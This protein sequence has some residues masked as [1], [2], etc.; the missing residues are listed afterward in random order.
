[1]NLGQ[2]VV[3]KVVNSGDIELFSSLKA[4]DFQAEFEKPVYEFT[5]NYYIEYGKLPSY[6]MIANKFNLSPI[7][8]TPD[9][10]P[11]YWI[12]ELKK[13]NFLLTYDQGINKINPYLVS[14]NLDEAQQELI[15]L[16]MGLSKVGVSTP[17]PQQLSDL[18]KSTLD[19][20]SDRRSSGGMTGITCGF[21]SLS[22]M[23]RGFTG[24]NCYVLAGRKKLGKSM[25]LAIMSLVAGQEGER[26]LMISME[27]TKDEYINRLLA[28]WTK[29]PLN[30]IVSGY[31]STEAEGNLR[32]LLDTLELAYLFQEGFFR[33]SVADLDLMISMYKPTIV[34][35]DGAYLLKPPTSTSKMSGWER[36]SETIKEVKLVAGRHDV[37]IIMSYQFNKEGD[38]HLSDSIR[39]IATATMGVY[40]PQGRDDQRVIKVM[41]NRNGPTGEI[42]IGWNFNDMEF[43]EVES[44]DDSM[45]GRE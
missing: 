28:L 4:E 45:E 23:L 33:T 35:I 18:F 13:R 9:G 6:S 1:M 34:Y 12:R 29:I 3:A 19:S 43:S 30:H 44:V 20:L 21:P 17:K 27:M 8:S 24:K 15:S 26:P 2:I 22:R 5:R 14:G 11:R 41:D 10:D 31:I 25:I 40:I 42:T 38:V 32:Q 37:P 7:E 16:C 36:V 39:Q